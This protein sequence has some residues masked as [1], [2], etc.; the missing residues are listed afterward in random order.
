VPGSPL[1]ILLVSVLLAGVATFALQ[2]YIDARISTV[3]GGEFIAVLLAGDK[4]PAGSEIT[5]DLVLRRDIP[6][7]YVH[8]KTVTADQEELVLGQ[9]TLEDIAM[10]ETLL[11]TDL[12]LSSRTNLTD[13]IDFGERAITIAVDKFSSQHGLIR[14][15]DRVDVLCTLQVPGED[16]SSDS[17]ETRLLLQNVTILAVDGS[18]VRKPAM[19][20]EELKGTTGAPMLARAEPGSSSGPTTVT[21]KLLA[22]DARLLAYAEEHGRVLLLLRNPNDVIVEAPV[23]V[24]LSDLS[25]RPAQPRVPE[26]REGQAFPSIA[27]PY[28]TVFEE[29]VRKGNAYWPDSAGNE[30]RAMMKGMESARVILPSE[31]DPVDASMQAQPDKSAKPEPPAQPEARQ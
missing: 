31:A 9:R 4:I 27:K 14:P 28:P 21:L 7:A 30:L 3:T 15:G 17:S 22:E 24:T 23:A 19:G 26:L 18:L 5:P 8:P 2:L 12:M 16:L 13:V 1:G 11:W 20:D 6:S 10:G 29:G 25:K